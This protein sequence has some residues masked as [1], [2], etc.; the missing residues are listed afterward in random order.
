MDK[1][2]LHYSD[3]GL[4]NEEQE[5]LVQAILFGHQHLGVGLGIPSLS[6]E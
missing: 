1:R 3:I 2:A 5:A 6:A 4:A